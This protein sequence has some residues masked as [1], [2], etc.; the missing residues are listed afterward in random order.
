MGRKFQNEVTISGIAEPN[1][2]AISEMP[3]SE[4]NVNNSREQFKL[5][6]EKCPALEKKVL[7]LED[8]N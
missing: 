3:S 6:E 5:L 2:C 7:D 4:E 1:L 8:K